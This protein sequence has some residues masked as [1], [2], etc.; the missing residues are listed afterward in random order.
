MKIH[1]LTK[2]Y[3]TRNKEN[4]GVNVVYLLFEESI[5]PKRGNKKGNG[6]RGSL[7]NLVKGEFPEG[8]PYHSPV[9]GDKE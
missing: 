1:S 8:S 7:V 5:L 2:H 9:T 4:N 6:E 3:H